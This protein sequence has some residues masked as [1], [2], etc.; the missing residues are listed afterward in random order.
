MRLKDGKS[1]AFADYP[2]EKRIHE[3]F[4]AQIEKSRRIMDVIGGLEIL[5]AMGPP[6]G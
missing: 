3:L 6:A 4:E 5:R 2:K 1:K